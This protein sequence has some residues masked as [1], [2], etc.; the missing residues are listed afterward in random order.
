MTS[1]KLT[2]RSRWNEL[3]LYR[4]LYLR[5]AI[6]CSSLTIPSLIP[7]S[8]ENAATSAEPYSRLLS[9][10]QGAGARGVS[11]LSAR[12]LLALYP[13]SQP[14]FRLV[15][16]KKQIREYIEQ[17]GGEEED[18]MSQMDVALSGIE[19]EI[20]TKLDKLQ[21]RGALFEAMKH[22]IVGGNALLYIGQ[23]SVR[24]Y[25]LRSYVV[26]RDPEGNVAEIVVRE[27]VSNDYLPDGVKPT[28][29]EDN[30]GKKP[31][32]DVY[33]H[34]T[35]SQTDNRVEWF[36]E[37][38]G[39]KIPNSQGFSTLENNPWICLRLMSIAGESYGRSLVEETLGDLQSLEKLSQA[40]V[41]GSLISAKAL[42]LVNPNGV[43]RADVLARSE[44]G[45]IVAG[46]VADVQALQIGKSADLS[47]ALQAMQLLEKRISYTFLLNE[48]IQRD[49]ERVTAEEIKIMAEQLESGLAGAFTMLSQELQLPLIRR[50]VYMM[51]NNNEMPPIPEG[52]INPQI[53]TGLEAIG[54]GNDRQR[55]T[56]FLQVI[57]AALG[58]EQTLSY[59]N[60]SELIRRFAASDG[61]DTAGLIKTDDDLQAEQAQQQE[62]ALEQQLANS[63]IS[64]GATNPPATPSQL[65]GTPSANA[66]TGAPVSQIPTRAA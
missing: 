3:E 56:N 39:K 37:Y 35:I 48:A 6:D 4:S 28:D 52:L 26:D 45:A 27:T 7:E 66:A 53:T 46:N 54:R 10:H 55:L 43:T 40:V 22:L 51:Q 63:A 36:Q 33:T 30:T 38:D 65:S 29:D 16:D 57:S 47:V 18:I 62:L 15:I 21:A 49:A 13:P 12:L 41:E 19:R 60:A 42:F 20:L 5:R 23:D 31:V 64:D 44:N 9:L 2:A 58:P 61:I 32:N 24:M 50:V 1:S 34:V 25:S 17:S 8:D 11:S 59:V 14:F